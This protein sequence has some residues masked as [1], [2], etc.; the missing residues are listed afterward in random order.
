MLRLTFHLN[1]LIGPILVITCLSLALLYLCV[2]DVAKSNLSF[3]PLISASHLTQLANIMPIIISRLS[4]FRNSINAYLLSTCTI[5]SYKSSLPMKF[6]NFY[7]MYIIFQLV[8]NLYHKLSSIP[9]FNNSF[10][11]ALIDS[12]TYYLLDALRLLFLG[13][14]SIYLF[15]LYPL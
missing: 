6:L 4:L 9:F 15:C 13:T 8:T 1:Q 7:S 14:L 5:M 3:V 10:N 2:S 11:N 12:N